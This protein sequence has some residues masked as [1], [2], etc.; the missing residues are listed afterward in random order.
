MGHQKIF[1]LVGFSA[2]FAPE[3]RNEAVT[4][5]GREVRRGD[6]SRLKVSKCHGCQ[7]PESVLRPSGV[8]THKEG[9]GLLSPLSNVWLS[10][11]TL[12]MFGV[13]ACVFPGRI[14]FWRFSPSEEGWTSAP[15]RM[16]QLGDDRARPVI[17]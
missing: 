13:I 6:P 7:R 2:S 12:V 17:V 5:T 14:F 11:D 8:H 1:S 4:G 16:S 9:F 15:R 10:S 3:R